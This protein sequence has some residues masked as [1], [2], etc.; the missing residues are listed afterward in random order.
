MAI[1]ALSNRVADVLHQGGFFCYSA[2]PNIPDPGGRKARSSSRGLPP[3]H[4][5]F[6]FSYINPYCGPDIARHMKGPP[7]RNGPLIC[8]TRG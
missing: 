7:S 6:R 1:E 2:V 8:P 5:H 3:R 4:L